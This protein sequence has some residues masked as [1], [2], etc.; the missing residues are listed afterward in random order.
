MTIYGTPMEDIPDERDNK[1]IYRNNQSG[2]IQEITTEEDNESS[3]REID[4]YVDQLID[5]KVAQESLQEYE[6]SSKNS[7]LNFFNQI[8]LRGQ[9]YDNNQT[10]SNSTLGFDYTTFYSTDNYGSF[11]LNINSVNQDYDYFENN[12]PNSN[13][14]FLSN[15]TLTQTGMPLTEN[16]T[17][18]NI[19]GTHQTNSIS[20]NV[21]TKNRRNLISRRFND[22]GTYLL[23]FTSQYNS[24][25]S[26]FSLTHGF[27]GDN[28]GTL[29][30]RF[31]KNNGKLNRFQSINAFSKHYLVSDFWKTTNFDKASFGYKITLDSEFSNNL[32]TSISIATSDNS[33]AFLAGAEQ[34]RSR[35]NQSIGMY[36]YDADFLWIDKLIGNDN[37]GAYYRFARN[38]TSLNYGVSTEYRRDRSNNNRIARETFL[39][40]I[41]INKRIS[42]NSRLSITY[43]YR[44]VNDLLISNSDNSYKESSLRSFINLTH[45]NANNSS[46]GLY[47]QTR[48][49]SNLNRGLSSQR[50]YYTFN[51][52]FNSNNSIDVNLEYQSTKENKINQNDYSFN[53]TWDKTIGIGKTLSLNTGYNGNSDKNSEI[54]GYNMSLNYNWQ[55]KDN[56]N[57]NVQVGYNNVINN[58]NNLLDTSNNLVTEILDEE[59]LELNSLSVQMSF[60]LSFG[61]SNNSNIISK[62]AGNIGSGTLIG[63]IFV[64]ENHDGKFQH[65]ERT[66]PN[67]SIFMDNIHPTKTNQ[68]G[69]YA[70]NYIGTG[71]HYLYINEAHL[72]LPWSLKSNQTFK[73]KIN[74]RDTTTVDIP[75]Y[76]ISDTIFPE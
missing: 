45:N 20:S 19:I 54:I 22:G 49:M 6:D 41:N 43:S 25:K 26:S 70:F 1:N 34:T 23:G 55:I 21:L 13:D 72:P 73:F 64:D 27:L 47:L 69:K 76:D 46:I 32:S 71:S 11:S 8:E 33:I 53:V 63:R 74:L 17:L 14:T 5:D 50:V 10:N 4:I 57:Y 7:K 38:T 75:V 35:F 51:H 2:F 18:N 39:N 52:L 15:Y 12:L 61:N 9:W 40:N 30:P 62:V 65:N 29:F 68:H 58:I 48:D 24:R 67:I 66:L 28:T 36:Y 37:Y 44:Q 60:N 56:M 16:S 59:N 31:K 42:R 3:T